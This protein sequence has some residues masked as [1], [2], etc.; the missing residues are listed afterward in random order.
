MKKRC[1][2]CG[3]TKPRAAFAANRAARDGLQGYCR[4]CVAE[5]HQARQLA[6][7]KNVRPRV[8][9]PEGHKYCRS[10]GEVKPHSQWHRNASASDGLSTSCKAC[11][12]VKSRAGHLKRHYGLTEAERDQLIADQA[13]VCCICLAAPAAHVDHCHETGRVRGVLC[14]SCNAALGQFKDRPDAIRRAAAYVEGIA[15]KPTLVAPGV[16]Q[17]PS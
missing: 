13:G 17:L 8:E 4:P 11:R 14:F 12:A 9:T 1:S 15:W 6:K 5:Y 7:G 3:E 10:C 2:R 16:Y